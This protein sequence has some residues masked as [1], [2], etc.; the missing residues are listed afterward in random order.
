MQNIQMGTQGPFQSPAG[1]EFRPDKSAARAADFRRGAPPHHRWGPEEADGK[2]NQR[3][4]APHSCSSA[5]KMD[6][7]SAS[8]SSAVSERSSARNT[9]LK[10]TDFFPSGTP[11]PR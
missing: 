3:N 10:A 11:L 5:S 6:F 4:T 2:Q 1:S 9:R 8:A 7:T